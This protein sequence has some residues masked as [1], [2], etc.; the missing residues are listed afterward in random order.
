MLFA[1][2]VGGV[3]SLFLPE[4]IHDLGGAFHVDDVDILLG[5]D[6]ELVFLD[7][8]DEGEPFFVVGVAE[9]PRVE[10]VLKWAI[11]FYSVKIFNKCRK[12]LSVH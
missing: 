6:A 2:V 1:H 10:I 4:V 7:A 8:H 9:A 11:V 3:D 12:F 5:I